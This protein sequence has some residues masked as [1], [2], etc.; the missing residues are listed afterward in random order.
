MAPDDPVGQVSSLRP[1]ISSSPAM[2]KQPGQ[3]LFPGIAAGHS[4]GDQSWQGVRMSLGCR[5]R[6]L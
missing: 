3:Q 1:G 2:I 6:G 4:S 5:P